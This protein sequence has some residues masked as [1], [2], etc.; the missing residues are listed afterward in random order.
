MHVMDL[1]E[2]H[3][4]AVEHLP[5]DARHRSLNLGTGQG[6]SVLD[7]VKG[8]EAATGITIPYEIVE[9]RPGDVP[10]L[11]ACPKRAEELL[12]WT[13]K[14]SLDDM[15]RDGWAWQSANPQGYRSES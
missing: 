14:R 7:V 9:R 12:G 2:A 10:K 8:F 15:C 11:Q 1:G 6:L 13:A 3:T 5:T 4:A